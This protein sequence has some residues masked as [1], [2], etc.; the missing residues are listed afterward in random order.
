MIQKTKEWQA[1]VEAQIRA[2]EIFHPFVYMNYANGPQKP[3]EAFGEAN[4]R[5]LKSIQKKYDP[6]NTLG[7]LWKGGYKL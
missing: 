5:R 2:R 4:V 3:Y 6:K 7:K 1:S